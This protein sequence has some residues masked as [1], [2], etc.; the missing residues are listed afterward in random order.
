MRRAAQDVF[1]GIQASQDKG[2]QVM[3]SVSALMSAI[4]APAESHLTGV[5]LRHRCLPERVLLVLKA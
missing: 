5:F 2:E 1:A 3:V 4:T